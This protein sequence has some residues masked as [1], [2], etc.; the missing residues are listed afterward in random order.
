MIT[1]DLPPGPPQLAPAGARA[2]F[3]ILINAQ[4]KKAGETH[5]QEDPIPRR[6]EAA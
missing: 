1:V 2:L 6:D 3:Q 4:A 5:N